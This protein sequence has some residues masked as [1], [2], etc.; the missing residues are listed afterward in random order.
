MTTIKASVRERYLNFMDDW[1]AGER[2]LAYTL[3]AVFTIL[4]VGA[5]VVP[6]TL[7]AEEP[8]PTS[9]RELLAT[10]Y[11]EAIAKVDGRTKEAPTVA[12][13]MQ[14]FGSDGGRSCSE[15][16]PKLH[17]GLIVRRKP[18]RG[19]QRP[20]YLDRVA[21]QELR[22]TMRVYCPARD[23]RYGAWLKQRQARA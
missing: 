17:A 4:A 9:R 11:V 6:L 19:R 21:L 1:H 20:S 18:L 16:I 14:A 8:L 13:A 3:I 10:R 12:E 7:S 22:T 23:A 15:A 2:H 5:V